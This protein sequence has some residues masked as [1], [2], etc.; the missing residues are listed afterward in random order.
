MIIEQKIYDKNLEINELTKERGPDSCQ[1]QKEI[2]Q[3][4]NEK[5]LLITKY[6]N[7]W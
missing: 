6:N 7:L 3:I 4:T 5:N 1:Y 2:S